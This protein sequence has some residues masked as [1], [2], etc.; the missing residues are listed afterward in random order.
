MERLFD[1]KGPWRPVGYSEMDHRRVRRACAQICARTGYQAYFN[2]AIK[3]VSFGFM[4][5]GEFFQAWSIPMFREDRQPIRFAQDELYD[6]DQVVFVLGSGKRS[7]RVKKRAIDQYH[8]QNAQ[9]R[10][11]RKEAAARAAGQI[12]RES[13]VD[14]FRASR[15]T[16]AVVQGRK[17]N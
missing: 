12:A 17:G 3:Q 6:V 14:R 5:N 9:L 8:K 10:R 15:R 13:A 2:D 7:H 16:S 1:I 4:R 11:E